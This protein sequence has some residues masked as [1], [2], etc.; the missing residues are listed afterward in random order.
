VP[1]CLADTSRTHLS[2]V[3]IIPEMSSGRIFNTLGDVDLPPSPVHLAIGMFDGL[4]LG[5][6][7]VIESAIHS[8]RRSDDLAGVLTFWPHPSR[9]F[10]PSDPTP[11]MMNPDDK[12]TFLF[13]LGLDFVVIHPFEAEFARMEAEEFLPFLRSQIT[14]LSAVYVGENW[15]FGRGRAGDVKRLIQL[16]KAQNLT[17]FS[18]PRTNLNGEPISS[19]RVRNHL[20]KGDIAKVNELLGYCYFSLGTV[21]PGRRVGRKL[22]FPTLNIEWRSELHPAYGVYA[23]RVCAPDR[24]EFRDGIANFGLQPTVNSGDSIPQLEIHVLDVCPWD[25]GDRLR[26]EW[27]GFIR[28]ERKFGSLKALQKQIAL[29]VEEVRKRRHAP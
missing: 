23:V 21:V 24:R 27:L 16:A 6:Q 18:A 9:L 8:A 26:T 12:V 29:D 4:H 25:S 19:T 1:L 14:G 11:Q 17:V 22:G 5:H 7:S 10:R 2:N 20:L 3:V 15:R 28:P 13:G